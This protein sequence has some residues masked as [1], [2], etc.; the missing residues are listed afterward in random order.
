MLRQMDELQQYGI[1]MVGIGV[2]MVGVCV[3]VFGWIAFILCSSYSY[4]P[5]KAVYEKPAV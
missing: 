2:Y 4:T 5:I 1:Y 3:C